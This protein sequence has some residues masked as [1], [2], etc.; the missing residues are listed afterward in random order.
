MG[1]RWAISRWWAKTRARCW[2]PPWRR[3][4]PSASGMSEQTPPPVDP[5]LIAQAVAL[6]RAGELV[7]LPTETVYGLGADALNPAAAA[8]IFAAK[9]R[10]ADHPLI[11]HLPDAEASVSIASY[12]NI[13]RVSLIGMD[14]TKLSVQLP[15]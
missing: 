15:N 1:A 13:Q 3:V 5:A 9:G 10:P 11:V 4:P 6:L 8:K 7:A 2:R 12:G 14:P